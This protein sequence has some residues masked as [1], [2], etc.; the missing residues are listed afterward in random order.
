MGTQ[1]EI[2]HCFPGDRFGNLTIVSR[3]ENDRF[4]RSQWVCVC[5]C[6]KEH[7]AAFFRM[8]SGHTK[9]C[10]C[11]KRG[12]VTHGMSS[13]KTYNSWL[14][15]KQRCN[16]PGHAEYS[17]YGGRGISVCVR[18][19]KFENFLADMG[20]RPDEMSIERIDSNGNYEPENC[21]WAT[22]SEQQRNRRSNINVTIDGVTKCI[23]DW[24]DD[25]GLNMDRVY[26]F[27]RRGH[28]PE[29]ALNK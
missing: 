23:K 8:K 2:K 16:Y 9:S 7:V 21:K 3:C 13:S 22:V 11:I 12:N 19:E 10:G 27:I 26:G 20:E 15:M 24:C 29:E 14:G 6:G 17:R 4:G 1:K 18:W 5:D 25:L 28:S